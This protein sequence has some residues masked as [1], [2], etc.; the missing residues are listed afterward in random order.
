MQEVV[1]SSPT[2]S[3][4]N[5]LQ[6]SRF[7]RVAA[8]AWKRSGAFMEALAPDEAPFHASRA[9]DPGLT[10]G[11]ATCRATGLNSDSGRP[12]SR[13]TQAYRRV[14]ARSALGRERERTLPTKRRRCATAFTR[15]QSRRSV[16]TGCR[17]SVQGSACQG[18]DVV[19][20]GG[21]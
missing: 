5:D 20:G 1:G 2:S 9:M 21:E 12:G 17:L 6:I 8:G 18:R 14:V 13:T 15:D 11:S 4:G 16:G 7:G 19:V 3:T 10:V